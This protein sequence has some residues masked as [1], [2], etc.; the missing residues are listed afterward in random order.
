MAE[1][2]DS[3]IVWGSIEEATAKIKLGLAQA[4]AG[5]FVSDEDVE[6]FFNEWANDNDND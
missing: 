1:E 6:A 4:S 5:E 3:S 2:N